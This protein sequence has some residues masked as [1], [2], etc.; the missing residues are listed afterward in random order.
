MS[1]ISR[2]GEDQLLELEL[3]KAETQTLNTN[4]AK[5]AKQDAAITKLDEVVTAI[6]GIGGGGASGSATTTVSASTTSVQL[7]ASRAERVEVYI[8]NNGS[9]TMWI[10]LGAAAVEDVAIELKKNDAY[11]NDKF[12]GEINGIWDSGASGNAQVVETFTV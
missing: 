12:T 11:I 9:K 1:E 7:V 2:S 3:I 10:N 6:G 8:R 5:E 4:G